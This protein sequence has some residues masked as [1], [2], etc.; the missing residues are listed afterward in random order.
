MV[1]VGERVLLSLM[2]G[3]FYISND[4]CSTPGHSRECH[5]LKPKFFVHK[6]STLSCSLKGDFEEIVNGLEL[7]NKLKAY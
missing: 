5:L 1:D 7:L 3:H 6:A 2:L 4:R